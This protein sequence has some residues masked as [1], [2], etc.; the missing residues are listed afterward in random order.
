MD[1]ADAGDPYCEELVHSAAH[2]AAEIACS[3]YAKLAFD[4][5]PTVDVVMAG[6]LFKSPTF[7]HRLM[8]ELQTMAPSKNLRFREEAS[9]PVL[10]GIALAN[11]LFA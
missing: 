7:R 3:V 5:E 6:S 2:L 1:H 9:S 4:R 8:E 11:A 10:G